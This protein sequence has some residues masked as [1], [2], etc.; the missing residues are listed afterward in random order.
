MRAKSIQVNP[1]RHLRGK[2]NVPG[3]KS[4]THRALI[5]SSLA[6]GGSVIKGMGRGLDCLATQKIIKRMGVVIEEGEDLFVQGR[7]I[8]GLE[9]P[10]DVL[11]CGNSATTMR[12]LAG[13]LAGQNFYSVLSGDRFL[14]E[15]PMSRVTEPLTMMGA[16][17]WGRKRGHFPPLSIL[18]SPLEGIRYSLPIPSAQV[19]SSL[20][21]AGL[22]AEGETCI[23]EP[24]Q[25]RDHTERML[26]FLGLPIERDDLTVRV[27]KLTSFPGREIS[28]PGDV[29][30]A[31]FFIGGAAILEGS[32]LR[33][34]SVG[35]NPT[36]MGFIDALRQMGADIEV[37][38]EGKRSG[39]EYGE[40][41]VR[42]RRSLEGTTIEGDMI[43]RLIDEMPIVAVVSCF[44]EGETI[45]KDARELRV[46]E[47]DRIRAITTELR[48]MGAEVEEREDG[49]II[50][51][52]G[53]LKGAECRSYNDHRMAMAL[54]MA[55][56]CA[57]GRTKIRGSD[58]IDTSF[59]GFWTTLEEILIE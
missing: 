56:L 44:A 19:K 26:K 58:C 33:V 13:L 57:E 46:K 45:I 35:L 59:P 22:Y 41:E 36:R 20:I 29:S 11:G 17:I 30:S 54:T 34:L 47:T 23:T 4:I 40:I 18:G 2:I 3:D 21:L 38:L 53:Y 32:H 14:R 25:S 28:V 52:R 9:E 55:G 16:K 10:G 12:L 31:A 39:E 8:H 37:H 27:K 15:R 43:P 24:Y 51:G 1:A 50:K 5:L 48:R 49:M 42:G 6:K 7:G